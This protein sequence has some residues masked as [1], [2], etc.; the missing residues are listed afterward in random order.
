MKFLKENILTDL[1]NNK[2]ELRPLSIFKVILAF[3]AQQIFAVVIAVFFSLLVGFVIAF[4]NK[5]VGFVGLSLIS[6]FATFI[7]LLIVI[8]LFSVKK[9]VKKIDPNFGYEYIE[10]IESTEV[11][12]TPLKLNKKAVLACICLGIGY[13]LINVGT[14]QHLLATV[15]M[16]PEIT[17]AFEE[18]L[19]QNILFILF[20]MVVEAAFVEEIMCRG[21]VLNG[22][23]NKYSPKVAILLSA[24]LFGILHM[25]IPQF[26]NATIMG[27]VFGIIYYQTRS[28]TACMIMHATNNFFACFVIMPESLPLKIAVSVAYILIGFLLFRKGF[29]DLNLMKTIKEFFPKKEKVHQMN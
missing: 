15:E 13:L 10:D 23:L 14:L 22:L 27:C 2:I 12:Q 4:T 24:T 6:S 8:K 3:F 28:L 25:N 5:D 16:P 18:I 26:I 19:D 21:F 7:A 9:R 1:I 29:K 20:T 11:R 17:K